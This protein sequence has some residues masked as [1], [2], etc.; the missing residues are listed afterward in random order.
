VVLEAEEVVVE[1]LALVVEA[2]AWEVVVEWVVMEDLVEKTR[3]T[4]R[5]KEQCMSTA[6][7]P[8]P[9]SGN[10]LEGKGCWMWRHDNK[11]PCKANSGQTADS[12]HK[13]N[14]WVVALV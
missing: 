3:G 12:W 13:G 6:S 10:D 9:R 14:L 5:Q 2:S 7:N 4:R 11:R 8:A 1:A